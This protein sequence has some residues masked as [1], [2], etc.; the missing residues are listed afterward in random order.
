MA[1]AAESAGER[2][3]PDF[4]ALTSIPPMRPG[5]GGSDPHQRNIPQALGSFVRNGFRVVS[6]NRAS[7]IAGLEKAYPD[8][9][10]REDRR[11]A[12]FPGRYGATFGALF[13][14]GATADFCGIINADVYLVPS[15]V[16]ELLQ[17]HP[18]TFFVARRSDVDLNAGGM[19][20]TYRRGIDA[21]FFAARRHRALVEDTRIGRLQMGAPFWDIVVPVVA[22]FHAPVTFLAPPLILHPVHATNWSRPHYAV[23]REAAS[24]AVYEHALR[25]APE[26]TQA[27]I[28]LD[29]VE[30]FI[31]AGRAP[32]G[33]RQVKA[34]ARVIDAWLERIEARSTVDVE[35][36]LNDP[37][38]RE[39]IGTGRE[40][41]A[42]IDAE[43]AARDSRDA[44]R[45]WWPY[46]QIR[47][48]LRRRRRA[49]QQG[50]RD[51]VFAEAEARAARSRLS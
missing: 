17:A 23:V 20:G 6:V 30:H 46:W 15:G 40:G 38:L 39:T 2:S 32:R 28:F 3:A 49:R 19:L 18:D 34:V 14:I 37:V 25:I 29:I 7:E 41:Y 47:L 9:A 35:I 1:L 31:G 27:R 33:R 48:A 12:V 24:R 22:S 13:D 36:D 16:R 43:H 50:K 11:D 10:F 42:L 5:S 8:V 44:A 21:V 26:N 45:G 51:R 4:V